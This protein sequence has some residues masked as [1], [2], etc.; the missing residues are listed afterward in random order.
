MG[1]LDELA[2]AARSQQTTSVDGEWLIYEDGKQTG[3]F[4]ADVVQAMLNRGSLSSDASVWQDGMADWVSVTSIFSVRPKPTVLPY[5]SRKVRQAIAW[6]ELSG[7]L[8][9]LPWAGVACLVLATIATLMPCVTILGADIR[10]IT[11]LPGKIIAPVG[12]AVA[13]FVGW[14][15]SQRRRAAIKAAFVG[16]I[17][18]TMMLCWAIWIFW[19]IVGGQGSNPAETMLAAAAISPGIGLYVA[20]LAGALGIGAFGVFI[21]KAYQQSNR[22]PKSALIGSGV[23][24]IVLSVGLGWGLQEMTKSYY[25]IPPT[26]TYGVQSK[27]QGPIFSTPPRRQR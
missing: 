12:F 5:S 13:G 21:A 11:F 24:G 14:A 1:A 16:T 26:P 19:E 10:P 25:G 18:S 22:S 15:I 9:H 23:V 8:A 20:M 4:S 7:Y 3:P 6:P 17:W 27:P 2:A